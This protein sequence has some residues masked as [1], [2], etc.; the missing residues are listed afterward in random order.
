MVDFHRIRRAREAEADALEG[1]RLSEVTPSRRDLF[2]FLGSGRAEVAVIGGIHRRDP[3]SGREWSE[4][5]VAALAGAMDDVEVAAIAVATDPSFGGS[6]DDLQVAARSSSAPVL[7]DDFL[8]RPALLY[9]SRL[10]GADAAVLP[11]AWLSDDELDEMLG[12]ASSLHMTAIVGVLGTED[13]PRALNRDRWPI[14]VWGLT[15]AGVLDLPLLGAVAAGVPPRRPIICLGDVRSA[16][17]WH[18][19]AG[20]VDAAVVAAPLLEADNL[21]AALAKLRQE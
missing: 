17:D 12:I 15:G 7:R 10:Y 13:L 5:D 18:R 20:L 19:L 6:L 16:E 11:V 4:I 14:G 8:H 9:Q 1:L 3:Y 21:E 2:Q